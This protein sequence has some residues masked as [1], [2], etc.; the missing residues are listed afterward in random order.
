MNRLSELF[1]INFTRADLIEIG[2]ACIV[3]L[4]GWAFAYILQLLVL[5]SPRIWNRTIG[6]FSSRIL[7]S[8]DQGGF[9]LRL[10]SRVVFVSVFVYAVAIVL[11]VLKFEA[12]G[13]AV[14]RMVAMLPNLVIGLLIIVLGIPLGRLARENVELLTTSLVERQRRAMGQLVQAVVLLVLAIIG[15]TQ[16]GIDVGIVT[17][18][19]SIV[20]GA[21]LG[22][23]AL[24]FGMGAPTH[25]ANV[26]SS[27]YIAKEFREGQVVTIA[28]HTGE[29]VEIDATAVVLDTDEG[30]VRVPAVKFAEEVSVI[31][32]TALSFDDE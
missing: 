13:S 29:I 14:D 20:V 9:T 22:G 12:L 18:M 32:K 8:E 15:F 11:N 17:I 2:L 30:L 25:V 28:G 4:V 23:L 19:V 7:V 6:R 1:S 10:L 31:H 26:I 24:A 5:R 3:L 16:L 21:A 27:R